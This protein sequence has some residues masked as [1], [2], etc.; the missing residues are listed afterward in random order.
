MRPAGARSARSQT[1]CNVGSTA[2]SSRS[3]GSA[4]DGLT[5]REIATELVVTVKAVEWHLSHVYRKLGI[6]LAG[7]SRA[8]ARR[9]L[10]V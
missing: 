6:Q 8:D 4:D 3:P 1:A 2:S 7:P 10:R 5:N 9:D